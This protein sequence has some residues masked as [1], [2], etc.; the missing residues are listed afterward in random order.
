MI[1]FFDVKE[2]MLSLT[3]ITFYSVRM[4]EAVP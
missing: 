4:A 2:G 3:R 1:K